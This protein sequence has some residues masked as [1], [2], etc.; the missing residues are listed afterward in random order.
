VQEIDYL[1]HIISYQGV[2]TDSRKIDVM[3]SWPSLTSVKQL[4]GFLGLTGYHHKF[5]M[6]YGIISRGWDHLTMIILTILR[7]DFQINTKKILKIKNL[8]DMFL[9]L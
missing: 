4:R 6:D 7:M 9:Y 3:L 2:A 1:C 5:I 8:I